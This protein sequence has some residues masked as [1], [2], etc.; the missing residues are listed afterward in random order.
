MKTLY[1]FLLG[2]YISLTAIAQPHCQI[3]HFSVNSGLSQGVVVGIMQDKKG[4]LWFATWNG[5]NKFDGYTFKSYKAFPGDGCTLTTNRFSYIAESKDGDIW[6]KSYDG[7]AYLFDIKTEKFID[8]LLPIESSMQQTNTVS[9]IYTLNK[10]V[11]WITC[12]QGYAFRIDEQSCKEGKGITLY[13]SFNQNLK[14]NNI[15]NIYEDSDGDEWIMTDKGVTIIGT[16][17][18]NSDYPFKMI[19]EY[20][21]KTYLISTSGKIALYDPKNGNIKFQELPC[22]VTDIYSISSISPSNNIIGLGTD[23]GFITYNT[24]KKEFQHFNIQTATQPSNEAH[25]FYQDKTGDVWIFANTSGVIKLNLKTGDKQHFTAPIQNLIQ[26]ERDNRYMIFE[27]HEGTLWMSPQKGHLCYYD[28]NCDQLKLYFAEEN[29]P[30]SLFAPSIRYYYSD[31]QQNLWITNDRGVDKISFYPNNYQLKPIDNGL[32]IRAFLSDNQKR[33]WVASKKGNVRIYRPDGTL[34]GYLSPQGI[35][36]TQEVTFGKSVYCFMEDKE[37]NIWMGTK[38]DGLILLKKKNDHSFQLQQF[39]HEPQNAYSLSNN[40]VYSIIQD[41]RGNIWAACYGGG[42]NLLSQ[43]SDGSIHFIHSGNRLKNYPVSTSLKIRHI[44]E[45]PDGVLL[46]GTTNGLLTFSNKFD[47]PE[48]IKFYHSNRIPNVDSSLSSNDVMQIF[49]D[50]R[51][52]TYVITFTGGISQV[53]STNLLTQDIKF[54]SYT[55]KDGLA[56]DLVLSMLEDTQKQLWV[57][58]ENTICKFNPQQGTFENYGNN[59]FQRE[60]N[61]TEAVPTLTGQ[62]KIVLGTNQGI[63]EIN[64][65]QMKKSSY[66]PPIAFTGLKIQGSQ[67]H[68]ALDDIKELELKPSE[69]NVTFQFAAIDYVNPNAIEYAYRLQGL[70]EEWNEAGNNRSATYINLPAGEY[71]LQI[72]SSNSDGVWTNNI[73][74]LPIHVLPTFWETYWAWLFYIVMFILFTTIIVYILFYIYRLR[75]QVDLE[76]HLSNIKL[77][78]F[79]DISHE[80]RTPLTLISS[81]VSEILEHEVISSTVREHLNLVHKNTERMLRLVNQLLDFRKIQNKKMKVLV[82]KTELVSQLQK[83]MESFHL[84]AKEKKID[85]QLH[86]D[87]DKIY[88]WVDRDKFEKIFFNLLSN[89][90]KYTPNGKKVTV[91]ILTGSEQVTISVSDEGIGIA[92]EKQQSLFYRFETLAQYNILQPSSGIGLSLVR[93][94]IELHHGNIQVKSEPESGSEFIVTLPKE[95]KVFEDDQQAEFILSDSDNNSPPMQAAEE[96]FPDSISPQ[97]VCAEDENKACTD[98]D[99]TSILIVEDN[100]ELRHFLW[101][102]LSETYTVLE[103]TNGKEGLK[104]A[105][106][107]IPDLI[108]S[109]VMMPVMDGLD[110]VK[111]IKADHDTCHI[112]IIVLSAKSSLDDRIAGLEQ[113]IDDYITKPFSSTYLKTRILS[114]LR[115]R[116]QLQELYLSKLS[117]HTQE[118]NNNT[119]EWEPSQPQ[120]TPYDEQFMQQVMAFMEEQM[121][122]TDITIDDFANKLMLS[123]TVFYRKLKS[124]VGL[125]PVDFV[126]EMRIKRAAQ[127]IER[128]EYSFS[129]IAYMTGFNDPKYFSRRFKKIMGVTPTEY[130]EKKESISKL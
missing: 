128:S 92:P 33:L 76:Q 55:I 112:P 12:E 50:S 19:K 70:E 90:F 4:F 127:L 53:I 58:S 45:A 35:I 115:Q 89:A 57:I 31:R 40:S 66:V 28:R 49:T 114:L 46:I 124:I 48:E 30:A 107:Y 109:D 101:N 91:N 68:V 71:Q 129:Q 23:N 39:I 78:F 7:R 125:T 16:K 72:R 98:D 95:E 118:E 119:N 94:L 65:E 117:E 17:Q 6:C 24:E 3:K 93:E 5:L 77:R 96:E 34:E 26:Y 85:F 126:C 122:N 10:G 83:I 36:T 13:S 56:S 73:R 106:Q 37:G 108:I 87:T 80:L 74:T 18:I 63:L 54:K 69:R 130:K 1:V 79:T 84:I 110:M 52:N 41:S 67:L 104:Y 44:A 22:S 29:N 99:R 82:E 116:Q 15:L 32:E 111:A 61:L 20:N 51:K 75:H 14:G 8:I 21:N 42:L 60:L 27:D 120:V 103:A 59:Y 47:Q 88:A 64:T 97:T 113:G 102:I 2:L 86:F 121:D 11:T 25:F 105:Q 9:N 123:R 38:K 100:H 43:A 81:P 62:K